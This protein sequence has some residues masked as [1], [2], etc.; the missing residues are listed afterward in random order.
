MEDRSFRVLEFNKIIEK[1]SEYAITSS[2]KELVFA[3]TPYDT[4]FEVEKKV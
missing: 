3:L 2:A 4:I 1:V